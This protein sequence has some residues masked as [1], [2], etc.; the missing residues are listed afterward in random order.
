MGVM[1]TIRTASRAPLYSVAQEDSSTIESDDRTGRLTKVIGIS[2]LLK[3]TLYFCR[4]NNLQEHLQ[5]DVVC[6]R[7]AVD[8][9][10]IMYVQVPGRHK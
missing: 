8:D 5:I 6:G 9:R 4:N 1:T 10:I 3:I 7:N 2:H